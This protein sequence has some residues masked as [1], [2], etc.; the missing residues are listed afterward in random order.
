[1]KEKESGRNGY[2]NDNVSKKGKEVKKFIL[3]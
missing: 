2:Y 1:V 3:P